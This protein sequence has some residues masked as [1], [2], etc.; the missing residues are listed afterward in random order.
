MTA[1]VIVT[2]VACGLVVACASDEDVERRISLI[3]LA[4]LTLAIVTLSI[5]L[6]VGP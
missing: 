5:V 1:L 2:I 6:G 3:A 4:A